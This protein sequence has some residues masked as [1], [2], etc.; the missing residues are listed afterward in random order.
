VLNKSEINSGKLTDKCQIDGR[1]AT[2]ETLV[3]AAWYD[4]RYSKGSLDQL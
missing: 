2:K 1:H 3:C 4:V